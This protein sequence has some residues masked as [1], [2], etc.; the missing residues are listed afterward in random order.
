MTKY[1]EKTLGLVRTAGADLS[2]VS[3]DN[4]LTASQRLIHMSATADSGSGQDELRLTFK[5]IERSSAGNVL[6]L[7]SGSAISGFERID[8]DPGVG[9]VTLIGDEIVVQAPPGGAMSA[10]GRA[11]GTVVLAEPVTLQG[12]VPALPL[13]PT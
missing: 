2:V 10:L 11:P 9:Q 5:E 12:T 13:K 6:R 4:T 8:F 1:G 7:G 3:L